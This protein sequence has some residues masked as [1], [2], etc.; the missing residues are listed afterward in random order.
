[1]TSAIFLMTASANKSGKS[2]LELEKSRKKESKKNRR[3]IAM[4]SYKQTTIQF[5]L[6]VDAFDKVTCLNDTYVD[7]NLDSTI[8]CT[9]CLLP[10]PEEATFMMATG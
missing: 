7:H 4:F 1:M 9:V 5:K 6:T 3:K 10:L 8:G 2:T